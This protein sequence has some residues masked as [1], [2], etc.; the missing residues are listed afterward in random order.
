MSEAAYVAAVKKREKFRLAKN[1][2]RVIDHSI[3]MLLTYNIEDYT[4]GRVLD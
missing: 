3:P 2:E 1:K 4:L